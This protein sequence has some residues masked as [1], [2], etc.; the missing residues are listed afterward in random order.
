MIS[1]EIFIFFVLGIT[2]GSFFN[3]CIYRLPRG[4]SISWPPSR[5]TSCNVPIKFR[6]NIPLFSY[7]FLRGRCQN[8]KEKISPRY[9]LVEAISGFFF[10]ALYLKFGMTVQ[11]VAWLL[12]TALLIIIT[13]IDIEFQLILNKITIPGL[14]LGALLS[15]QFI[16][17]PPLEIGLGSVL[18]SGLLA[19]VAVLG[20]LIFRK[21]SMGMGDVKMAGMV[22]V[23]LGVKG[24]AFA[25][26]LG[27]LIAG[28][29]GFSGMAINRLHRGSYLPFGPFI[30]AGTLVHVFFGEEILRWY[31]RSVGLG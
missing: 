15:W 29:F 23:F 3:V 16:P 27:F 5:C 4:E 22:G 31:L 20:K 9:P 6:H 2:F 11:I 19:G 12:L 13:F 28:I 24:I 14:F 10:V 26:F 25:L 1:S 8:C 21:E 17:L 18:G 7:L 30:A